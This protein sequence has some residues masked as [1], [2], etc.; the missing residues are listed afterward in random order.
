[1]GLFSSKSSSKTRVSNQSTQLSGV[2]S[3]DARVYNLEGGAVWQGIDENEKELFDR[4][5]DINTNQTAKAIEG[6]QKA[7]A[8]LASIASQ[9]ATGI[10]DFKAYI[11]ALIGLAGLLLVMRLN[12]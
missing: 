10:V 8:S 6:E 3:E 12:K 1:M 11:P 2:A 7:T 9:K 5:I 4:L